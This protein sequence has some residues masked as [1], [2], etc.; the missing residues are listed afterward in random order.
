[1]KRSVIFVFLLMVAGCMHHSY[2]ARQEMIDY[3]PTASKLE[4]YDLSIGVLFVNEVDSEQ[5][6]YIEGDLATELSIWFVQFLKDTDNFNR[7]VNLNL[8]NDKS[9]D[10]VLTAELKALMVNDPGVSNTSSAMGVFYGVIPMV[11]HYSSKKGIVS[12]ASMRFKLTDPATDELIWDQQITEAS[13]KTTTLAELSRASFAAISKTLSTLLSDSSMP[14][15][16][17]KLHASR[18][19]DTA[20]APLQLAEAAGSAMSRNPKIAKRWAVV[21]GISSYRDSRIP[22]LNYASADAKAFYRWLPAPDKGAFDAANVR[23]LIEKEATYQNIREALFNWLQNAI[24]EDLVLLYFAGHGTP[25]SPDHPDN[26]F[27]LCH[28]SNY[29]KIETTGFPMWDVET[30]LRRFI[31]AKKV[32]VITDACHSGGIGKSFEIKRRGVF[33]APRMTSSMRQLTR[34][35]DT[36]AVITASDDKE[37]SQESQTW[38][39]GHGVFTYYFIRG[40]EGEADYNRDNQVTLGELIPYVSEK[41][42]RETGNAQTPTVAGKFDPALTVSGLSA[43]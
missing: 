18:S 38:G 4:K 19:V 28:D 24:E 22:A 36:V 25:A 15:E 16:L 10:V 39:G 35:S 30:A 9:V 21:I 42:R 2:H 13:T 26:L 7:V 33:Q 27:L 40:L 17:K 31:K 14:D 37:L 3:I 20:A 29:H 6:K 34:V 1:M 11:E 23:L 32:I 5:T 12:M 41:V 8:R 43:D